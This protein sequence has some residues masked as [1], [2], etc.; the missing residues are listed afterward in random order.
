MAQTGNGKQRK[1]FLIFALKTKHAND[2]VRFV[3]QKNSDHKL[4]EI[5]KTKEE[6]NEE[7]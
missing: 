1:T 7:N 6:M 2:A 3:Q 4:L 5:R